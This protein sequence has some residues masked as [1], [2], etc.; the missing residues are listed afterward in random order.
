MTVRTC[1]LRAPRLLGANGCLMLKLQQNL[2]WT[3]GLTFRCVLGKALRIVRV[4][5]RVAERCSIVR[6]L[7]DAI[8]IGL[9]MLLLVSGA[10]RLCSMLPMWVIITAWLSLNRLSVAAFVVTLCR[11]RVL[12][13]MIATIGL[14]TI[15]FW[16]VGLA[17]S[18]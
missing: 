11:L 4:S 6:F 12:L 14:G 5:M 13:T 18:D 8:D 7:L 9:M 1:P 3:G 10:V 2:L 15:F 17:V 16:D